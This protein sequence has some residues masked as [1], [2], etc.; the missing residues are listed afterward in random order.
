[1]GEGP[2]TSEQINSKG[3]DAEYVEEEKGKRWLLLI[4]Q[5][6]HNEKS[7]LEEYWNVTMLV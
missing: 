6:W 1:M 5:A 2:H 3:W 4:E 7:L